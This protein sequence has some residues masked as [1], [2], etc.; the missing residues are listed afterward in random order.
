MTRTTTLPRGVTRHGNGYRGRA[1]GFPP[2]TFPTVDE[3]DDYARECRRRRRDGILVPPS[4]RELQTTTTRDVAQ[5]VLQRLEKVGGRLGRPYS[6][7]GL[8]EARKAARPWTGE[9]RSSARSTPPKAV[10]GRDTPFADLPFAALRPADCERYL[11]FRQA[12]TPRA[13]R[14]ERQF[15]ARMVELAERRGYQFD[16]GLRALEPVRVAA[17]TRVALH[18]SEIVWMS[19]YANEAIWRIFPLGASLGDRIMELLRAEVGWLDLK[20]CRFTVPA[21]ATKERRERVL[22]LLPEEVALFRQQLLVRAGGTSLLFPRE[23]GE[24]WSHTGFYS[25]VVMP[26]R[27]KAAQAWR[28]ERGLHEHADTPFEQVVRDEQGEL[29]YVKKGHTPAGRP[30][31]RVKT[32]GFAPHDLRRS[33]SDLLVDELGLPVDVAAAR[34]GHKDGGYLL[35]TRYKAKQQRERVRREIDRVT[36]AGGITGAL[37]AAGAAS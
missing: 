17:R 3:A 19:G 24:P 22:D 13:A 36:D 25:S 35:L 2:A 18:Y 30:L 32:T 1:H 15:L 12:E 29:V 31:R 6:K 21:W 10:D 16:A 28:A 23:D 20:A 5:E 7:A 26:M 34:L 33:A 11:E 9:Q 14:G 37:A 4:R 27:G 8:A